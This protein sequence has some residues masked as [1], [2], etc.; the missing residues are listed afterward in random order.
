MK[1][2]YSTLELKK[3]LFYNWSIGVR[4][5]LGGNDLIDFNKRMEQIYYRTQTLFH[6][7]NKDNHEIF[8]VSFLDSWDDE[9]ITKNEPVLLN[10]LKRY[11]SSEGL[12]SKISKIRVPF[13][14]PDL[15][16][17]FDTQTYRYCLK[18]K[19][20]DIDSSNFLE[21]LA[22]QYVG[23]VPYVIGDTYIINTTNNTIFHLYDDRGIDVISN[24]REAIK[25]LYQ[26]CNEWILNYDKKRIDG[27]FQTN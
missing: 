25:A 3:P 24:T 8:L 1:M 12:I 14:Y 23:K 17:D 27:I 16:D 6:K 7:L 2:T 4:F 15:D 21:A 13:R 11:V 20:E 5:E 22:N 19:V 9:P 18:C 26:E 10:S